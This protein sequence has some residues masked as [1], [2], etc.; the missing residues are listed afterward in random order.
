MLHPCTFSMKLESENHRANAYSN[1]DICK[2][3]RK[4]FSFEITLWDAG[5]H[6]YVQFTSCGQW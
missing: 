3:S 1:S 5:R 6:M 4:V 2:Y